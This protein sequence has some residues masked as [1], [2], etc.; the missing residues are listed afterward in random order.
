[1]INTL[2]IDDD[3]PSVLVLTERLKAFSDVQIVATAHNGEG[4]RNAVMK[5]KPD[6]LFLDI[7][8]P[9][10]SGL[11]FLSSLDKNI[12][13]DMKVV[14]Y[15]SYEKYL[16]QALRLQAFDFLLKPVNENEL[17]LV[18]NRFYLHREGKDNLLRQNS[19][20]RGMP[21]SVKSVLITTITNDKLIVRPEN[22]GYFKYDSDRK[23]WKVVLNS[24]QYFILKHQTTADTI[25]SYA[26]EFIQIHK[27]YIINI[28]YLY[29]ISEN[30]C[31]LL[32]PFNK[33]SELK[34]SKMYKKKLLDK[35]Y[36]M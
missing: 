20:S 9:D 8:L 2:I 35:F 21:L 32:P 16:L 6:L 18:M 13:W 29:I 27:S 25:L 31:T 17:S 30:S 11:D 23:L 7:E 15:T 14:F 36:D 10:I 19:P 1:M 5:Y 34:I 26:P 33:V 4:G 3:N 12:D 22:I 24:L 28:N